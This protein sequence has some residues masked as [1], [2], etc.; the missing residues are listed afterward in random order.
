M[1]SFLKELSLKIINGIN[2]LI[3][4]INGINQYNKLYKFNHYRYH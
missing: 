1:I 3:N 4:I 2:K